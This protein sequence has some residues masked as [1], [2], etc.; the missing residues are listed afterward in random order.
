[1]VCYW[2]IGFVGLRVCF[3]LGYYIGVVWVIWV[4]FKSK[5]CLY[6]VSIVEL[7]SFIIC[8]SGFICISVFGSVDVSIGVGVI[9]FLC[10]I[11][12]LVGYYF[13]EGWEVI[14]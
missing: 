2:V 9:L 3:F 8:W 12:E 11:W 4:F 5:K 10:C 14:S 7:G 1:M 6:G 13:N